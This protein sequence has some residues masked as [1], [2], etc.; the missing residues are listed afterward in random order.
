MIA[1]A[2]CTAMFGRIG[3]VP[4][5]IALHPGSSNPHC[6]TGTKE[7]PSQFIS[8]IPALRKENNTI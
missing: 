2:F 4:A 7:Q 8:N 5:P 3:S 1:G 6:S